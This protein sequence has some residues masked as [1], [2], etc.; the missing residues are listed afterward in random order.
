MTNDNYK[1]RLTNLLSLGT[2][3]LLLLSYGSNHANAQTLGK[4]AT[5]TPTA[6]KTQKVKVRLRGGRMQT[7]LEGRSMILTGFDGAF[8]GGKVKMSGRVNPTGEGLQTADVQLDR[9]NLGQVLNLTNG[10][11]ATALLNGVLVSGAAKASWS[12]QDVLSIGQNLTGNFALKVGAG[13]I[14]DPGLLAKLAKAAGMQKLDPITF[15]GGVVKGSADA[16][17]LALS[18]VELT[19]PDFSM[20]ANGDVNVKHD[21]MD[22]VFTVKVAQKLA[23]QSSF[24]QLKNVFSLFKGKEQPA[25]DG[26]FVNLPTFTVAGSLRNPEIKLGDV[27]KAEKAVKPTVLPTQTSDASGAATKSRK[28]L[29][30]LT[31][32]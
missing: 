10:A 8:A 16:G 20:V 21:D 29:A 2:V 23:S 32:R 9:V 5:L 27:A 22:L 15:T 4:S 31:Q 25:Q 17:R 24:F 19:G 1:L 3:V 6:G 7:K 18:H 30:S 14:N 26:G 28:L 11:P 13:Q 12:G